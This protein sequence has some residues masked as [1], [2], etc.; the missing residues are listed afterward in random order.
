LEPGLELTEFL[1]RFP[2]KMSRLRESTG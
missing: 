2:P 1:E